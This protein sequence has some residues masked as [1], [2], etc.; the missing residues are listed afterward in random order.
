[1]GRVYQALDRKLG[2]TVAIKVLRTPDEF[3]ASRFRGEAEITA[4]L[5][6]PNITRIFEIETTPDGRPYLVLE[7]AEGGSLDKELRGQP[8]EPRRA[9]EAAETL[10]RAIQYAHDQGVIHRDLKPANVLRAKDGTL[11]VTDFGLAKQYEVASGLT[12]SGAVMGTPSYMAPEQAAGHVREVGPAADVYGLGAILY[13]LLT[14]RP[15]FRGVNM[16]DTLEQ[17]RWADPAPPSRLVPRLHKDLGTVCLKCLAKTP[18][19]RY[20]TAGELAADLRR[21]LDGETIAARPAPVWERTWRQVRRRP[22]EA[23]ATA[24]AGL[25]AVALAVG[26]VVWRQ[27]AA[28]RQHEKDLRAAADDTRREQEKAAQQLADTQRKGAE[29]LRQQADRS[30]QALNQIRALVLDGG[31]LSRHTGLEPLYAALIGYYDGLVAQEDSGYDPLDLADGFTHVGDLFLRTG[32]KAKARAAYGKAEGVCAPL[33]AADPRARRTRAEALLKTARVEYELGHD[34]AAEAARADAQILWEGLAAPDAD[35]RAA[36]TARLAEVWHLRGQLLGRG[37][38]FA[39]AVEAY[40]KAVRLRQGLAEEGLRLSVKDVAQL[41]AEARKRTLEYLR[42][43]GRGY[44]Y[45]GDVLLDSRRPAEADRDYWQSHHIREKVARVLDSGG[46]PAEGGLDA[47]QQLARSWG[48]FAELH[49][50]ARALGTAR[51]F[52]QTSLDAFEKL[53]A[54]DPTNVEYKLDRWARV[55]QL[56]ELDLLLGDR[57]PA[58]AGARLLRPDELPADDSTAAGGHSRGA[59]GTLAAAHTLRGV[60][61]ADAQRPAAREELRRARDLFGDL[62]EDRP[63][64]SVD[65]ANLYYAAAAITLAAELDDVPP[66]HPRWH[67]ALDLLDRA[68]VRQKYRGKHPDDVAAFRAFRAMKDD[69]RFKSVLEKLRD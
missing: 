14:G 67:D 52:A 19:R 44:G 38:E 36:A 6:H 53:V 15:P 63:G 46:G 3:E 68:V 23:A 39:G 47:R 20:A 11:K 41:P 24:A 50:R 34:G 51:Y 42:D 28:D 4:R 17:V 37:R 64:V 66:A 5:A 9:A 58:G 56:V 25:L 59:R 54:D 32:D 1:M 16:V 31:K 22:W 8:Q 65:P 55:N 43:L 21:W 49:T 10:A 26:L 7:F 35:A 40:G 57:A 62:C 18:A 27:E 69:P 2:R 13:E 12:P 33:A 48:N 60:Q 29:R 30:L 61:L 45:R